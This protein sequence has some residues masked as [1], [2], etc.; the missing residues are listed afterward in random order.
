MRPYLYIS[1][2]IGLE[3][4]RP[5]KVRE[6]ERGRRGRANI[7]KSHRLRMGGGGGGVFGPERERGVQWC[8]SI[9]SVMKKSL[10]DYHRSPCITSQIHF[11]P[12]SLSSQLLLLPLH[13]FFFFPNNPL[14][15]I[16]AHT[17]TH[18]VY[19]RLDERSLMKK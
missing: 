10:S 1:K 18:D 8:S 6:R 12:H 5:R 14:Q 19:G 2:S 4:H 9:W 17:H 13:C 15:Y 11:D 3:A 16:D 7:V